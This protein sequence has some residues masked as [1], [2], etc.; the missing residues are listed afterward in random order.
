MPRGQGVGTSHEAAVGQVLTAVRA[1]SDAMDR[2]H[3]G[4]KADMA[5]N[6][7]DLA[8]L[9]MLVIREQRGDTVSPHDI[10]RHLRISTAATTK[11]LDRLVDAGLVVRRPHPHDGRARVIGLTDRSRAE[12]RAHFGASVAAMREVAVGF[13]AADLAVITD[14]LLRTATAMDP[15]P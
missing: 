15:E 4:M 3:S 10:S 7:T 9:R 6:A 12:F 14:F 11:L 13:S 8:A 2:L 5:M 1:F